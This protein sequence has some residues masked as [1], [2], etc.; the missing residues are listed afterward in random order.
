MKQ[1]W[2]IILTLVVAAISALWLVSSFDYDPSNPGPHVAVFGIVWAVVTYV[3]SAA[4]ERKARLIEQRKK[5]YG[6]FLCLLTKKPE[7]RSPEEEDTLRKYRIQ[8]LLTGS[9]EVVK[10][11][12]S[13]MRASQEGPYK[14]EMLSLV[15]QMRNECGITEKIADGE[16]YFCITKLELPGD[17][18][19]QSGA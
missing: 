6:A 12:N 3:L 13:L 18:R 17:P 14:T 19:A 11:V 2:G 16:A 10:A 7:L 4:K 9:V 8:L 5:D 1:H 15:K